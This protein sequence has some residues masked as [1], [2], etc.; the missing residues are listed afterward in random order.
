[1][2]I[3]CFSTSGLGFRETKGR[4]GE[5]GVEVIVFACRFFFSMV[6]RPLY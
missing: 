4:E 2:W 1:M 3:L 6:I 5:E